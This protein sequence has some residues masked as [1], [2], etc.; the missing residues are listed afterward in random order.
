MWSQR[1]FSETKEFQEQVDLKILLFE[2]TCC[3]RASICGKPLWRLPLNGGV[4]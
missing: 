1:H 3:K 2:A 4:L